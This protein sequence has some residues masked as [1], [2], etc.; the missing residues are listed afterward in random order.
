MNNHKKT[1][2]L[3]IAATLLIYSSNAFALTYYLLDTTLTWVISM[4][5]YWVFGLMLGL[6]PCAMSIILI[7]TSVCDKSNSKNNTAP[8]KISMTYLLFVSLS[9]ALIGFII[10]SLGLTYHSL[11]VNKWSIAILIGIFLILGLSMLGLFHVRMPRQLLKSITIH[12]AMH[13]H[14][15]YTEAAMMGILASIIA[16]PCILAP[17]IALLSYIAITG[18]QIHATVSMIFTGIGFS[19]PLIAMHLFGSEIIQYAGEWQNHLKN[20]FG[21]FILGIAAWLFQQF[22]SPLTMMYIWST[23]LIF[24]SCYISSF[25]NENTSVKDEDEAVCNLDGGEVSHSSQKEKNIRSMLKMICMFIMLYGIILMIAAIQ[26][27][28][29]PLDPFDR[30]RIKPASASQSEPD[31]KQL[32][33]GAAITTINNHHARVTS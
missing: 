31:K 30:A 8:L 15:Q 2:S 22:A 28:Q 12:N 4:V 17:L 7:M 19:T 18:N 29:N 26:G 16:A 3:F 32:Q 10:S 9:Y 11:L 6:T 20:I 13:N 5:G 27:N 14:S 1:L 33:Q 25:F 21:I 24:T 23:L